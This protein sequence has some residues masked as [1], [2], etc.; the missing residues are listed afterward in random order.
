MISLHFIKPTRPLEKAGKLRSGHIYQCTRKPCGF[1]VGTCGSNVP[2]ASQTLVYIS[3][4]QLVH[5]TVAKVLLFGEL[6]KYTVIF[7]LFS[8]E[9]TDLRPRGF[10][11]KSK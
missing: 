9:D 6:A 2:P 10:S 11:V 1:F 8:V 4:Q 7:T 3:E 5:E